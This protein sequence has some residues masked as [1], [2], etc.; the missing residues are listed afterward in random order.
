MQIVRKVGG[1]KHCVPCTCPAICVV[2]EHNNTGKKGEDLAAEFLIRNGY[3]VL[4]RNFT[5]RRCEID[6]IAR[7]FDWLLFVEVKTRTS[8][9]F[10]HPEEFVESAQA[11]RIVHA[12][13]EFIFTSNWK[14]HIRFDIISVT[15]DRTTHIIHFEDAL[16]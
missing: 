5:F 16:N 8:I 4:R 12:A 15:I 7:K 9:G 14:G 11:E 1:I 3:E 2:S 6:I 10:G 13:E